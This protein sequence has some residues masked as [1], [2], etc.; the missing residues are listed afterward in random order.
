MFRLTMNYLKGLVLW[1]LVVFI[2]FSV[3]DK[4]FQEFFF[5]I[6]SFQNFLLLASR[7]VLLQL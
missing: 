5:K 3:Q 6:H 2:K 1:Y 7:K 4:Q